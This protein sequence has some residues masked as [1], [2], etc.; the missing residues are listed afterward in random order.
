MVTCRVYA[1]PPKNIDFRTFITNKN[2]AN[3]DN[4]FGTSMYMYLFWRN[5]GVLLM[6]SSIR[7]AITVAAKT[8]RI[9]QSLLLL[10]FKSL[11]G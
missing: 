7:T 2:V 10:L 9:S 3:M 11:A 6:T 5:L 1:P 8:R 4:N